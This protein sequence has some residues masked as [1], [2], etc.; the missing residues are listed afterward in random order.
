MRRVLHVDLDAFYASVEQRDD[1]G[2][3][4]R[5]VIVGGHARRGVVLAA[6][7]EVRPLGVRSAMPMA[8]ALRRAPQAIV[9]PPRFDAYVSASRAVFAIFARYTPLVEGLSLD[10][11]FLELTGTERLFGPAAEVARRIRSEIRAEVSLPASAGI[12]SSKHVAKIATDFAKP[13]GQHEVPPGAERAFLAP[14]PVGRLLGVGPK[15]EATLLRRGLRTIGDLQR[16]DPRAL[17]GGAGPDVWTEDEAEQ[18]G[19]PQAAA[20]ARAARTHSD[21]LAALVALA[22]GEDS[23]A[24]EPEREAKSIGAEDTFEADVHE[25]ETLLPMLHSQALRVAARLR[26]AEL[27]AR[28]VVLKLKTNDFQL[29]TRRTTLAAPTDDGALLF[30]VVTGLLEANPPARPVRL[31][32][33][34]AAGLA[35]SAAQLDLLNARA[36]TLNRT[37]DAIA[38]RFGAGSVL[39][40]DVAAV[41][42]PRDQDEARRQIGASKLDART[43]KAPPASTPPRLRGPPRGRPP[44]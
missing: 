6:S 17:G 25:P 30:R 38:A 41:D 19:A 32:G 27:E 3:R 14:L 24:V 26:A 31:C 1:P 5:P 20:N 8:E 2:L 11:A 15:L 34:Q 10:E 13:D 29:I 4:G 42:D 12:A 36:R 9:V 43:R 18:A 23:R 16:L 28:V 22:R 21:G 33:V 37:I 40:A 44:R 39:P 35:P 7:Y